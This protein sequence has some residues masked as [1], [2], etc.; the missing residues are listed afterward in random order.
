MKNKRISKNREVSFQVATCDGEKRKGEKERGKNSV[1]LPRA[2]YPS[3]GE[4]KGVKRRSKRGN[5]FA[6]V[7]LAEKRKKEKKRY[8]FCIGVFGYFH[9]EVK[10]GP[11]NL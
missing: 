4:K 10:P 7:S 8:P 1:S 3:D 9:E 11:H 6:S 2:L 5:R